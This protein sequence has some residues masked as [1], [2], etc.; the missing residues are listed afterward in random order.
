LSLTGLY[1]RSNAGS[2]LHKQTQI[3]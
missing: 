3:M 1:K 2:L